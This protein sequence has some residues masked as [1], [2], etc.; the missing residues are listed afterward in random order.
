MQSCAIYHNALAPLYI[1]RTQAG[2]TH[3]VA[4]ATK[5][6]VF[7]IN[8][9]SPFLCVLSLCVCVCVCVCVCARVCVCVRVS[10][11]FSS[12]PLPAA[13]THIRAVPSVVMGREEQTVP[14]HGELYQQMTAQDMN[15]VSSNTNPPASLLLTT[16]THTHTH[17]HDVSFAY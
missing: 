15:S 17:T 2:L 9:F 10:L 1:R 8:N 16:H 12:H 7:R 3:L 11:S 13:Q 4:L 5:F 6:R 14:R